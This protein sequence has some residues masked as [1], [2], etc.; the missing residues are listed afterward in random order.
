M[1][2]EVHT[3]VCLEAAFTWAKYCINTSV[4]FLSPKFYSPMLLWTGVSCQFY[5]FFIINEK[6]HILCPIVENRY[7][8]RFMEIG[9]HWSCL[10]PIWWNHFIITPAQVL[11]SALIIFSLLFVLVLLS[12]TFIISFTNESLNVL[13]IPCL[14]FALH[15]TSFFL[16]S[17]PA[18]SSDVAVISSG[19][20]PRFSRSDL[21]L[22]PY[23]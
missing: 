14:L 13:P 3:K 16:S 6:E 1:D 18:V 10:I 7:T 5:W 8:Q 11:L 4:L 12:S 19:R 23:R 15:H 17:P 2:T 22:R 21:A 9:L 20:I